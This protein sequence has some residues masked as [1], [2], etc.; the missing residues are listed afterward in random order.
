MTGCSSRSRPTSISRAARLQRAEEIEQALAAEIQQAQFRLRRRQSELNEVVG[1]A[2]CSRDAFADFLSE[3]GNAWIRL[4]S[5]KIIGDAII[6]GCRGYCPTSVIST[7]QRSKTLAE[8]VGLAVDDD[9]KLAPC[10][11]RTRHERRHRDAGDRRVELTE[12][13]APPVVVGV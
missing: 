2:I 11:R 4:R 7:I 3:L 8:R 5:L 9:R 13:F 6:D 12:P 1:N 10:P